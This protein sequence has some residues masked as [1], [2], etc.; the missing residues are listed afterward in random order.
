MFLYREYDVNLALVVVEARKSDYKRKKYM[1]NIET[2]ISPPS[3][4]SRRSKRVFLN[5]ESWMYLLV[6][7]DHL[8]L[9]K[10]DHLLLVKIDRMSI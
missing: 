5:E 2:P 9:V 8:L 3:M 6:K 4:V 10:I 1:E 7:I